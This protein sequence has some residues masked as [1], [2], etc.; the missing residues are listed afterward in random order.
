MGVYAS[1]Y[2]SDY[3]S[4]LNAFFGASQIFIANTG[5]PFTPQEGDKVALIVPNARGTVKVVP[6]NLV[7]GEWVADT[8]GMFGGTYADTSDGRFVDKVREVLGHDF[9]GAVAIH[10]RME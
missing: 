2:R 7:D 3:D 6:A 5:G 1:V 4:T 8:R 10:D 9:Y